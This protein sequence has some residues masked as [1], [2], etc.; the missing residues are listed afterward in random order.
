LTI[1]PDAIWIETSGRNNQ[2]AAFSYKHEVGLS[3]MVGVCGETG[4]ALALRGRGGA[5]NP[6]RAMAS[7]VT[8]SV[9][10]IPA[11]VAGR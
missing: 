8:E 10:A 1:D 4:D 2:G 9:S 7:L 11:E 6:G 5:A 3:S